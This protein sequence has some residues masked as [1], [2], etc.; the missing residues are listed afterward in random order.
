MAEVYKANTDEAIFFKFY[1]N[2]KNMFHSEQ[3]M[4]HVLDC[5]KKMC[6]KKRTPL[7]DIGEDYTVCKIVCRDT[8]YPDILCNFIERDAE[9]ERGNF[10]LKYIKNCKVTHNSDEINPI[11]GRSSNVCHLLYCNND[12]F[13]K[14]SRVTINGKRGTIGEMWKR[15]AIPNN[16]VIFVDEEHKDDPS[17]DFGPENKNVFTFSYSTP[18]DSDFAPMSLMDKYASYFKNIMFESEKCTISRFT[19]MD[20]S[21]IVSSGSFEEKTMLKNLLLNIFIDENILD[22]FLQKIYKMFTKISTV[23]KIYQLS[24]VCCGKACL[25]ELIKNTFT[26]VDFTNVWAETYLKEGSHLKKEIDCESYKLVDNTVC[27]VV[28]LEAE[29]GDIESKYSS[30]MSR[31]LF[32]QNKRNAIVVSNIPN[33]LVTKTKVFNIS[34]K[35][36]ETEPLNE[37]EIKR[38][39]KIYSLIKNSTYHSL[40]FSMC[41]E[42]RERKISSKTKAT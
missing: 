38:D 28:L 14:N 20:K 34:R 8:L 27:D 21:H 35:F 6:Y 5:L 3:E 30:P 11:F 31:S 23:P 32:K 10:N 4:K 2:L 42:A 9:K 1:S 12:F 15:C 40:F 13:E 26:D 22:D 7:C 36:V 19:H 37:F 29:K 41:K 17:L 16:L 39:K 33:A 18:I 24:G 25:I